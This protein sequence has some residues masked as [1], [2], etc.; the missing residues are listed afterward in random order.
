MTTGKRTLR[1]RAHDIDATVRIGNPGIESPAERTD[2]ELI[3]TW[4]NTATNH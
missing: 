1:E 4:D 3:E 2:A